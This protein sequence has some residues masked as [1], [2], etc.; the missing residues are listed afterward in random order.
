MF[1]IHWCMDTLGE[2][3]TSFV[4]ILRGVAAAG[5]HVTASSSAGTPMSSPSWSRSSSPRF[6]T[7]DWNPVA[8]S[9][10]I[11]TLIS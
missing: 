4:E 8:I 5:L 7:G 10:Q 9:A 3:R 2:P 6:Q 11:T 1:R